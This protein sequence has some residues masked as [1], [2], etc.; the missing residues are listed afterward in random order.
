MDRDPD[1][2][3]RFGW[4]VEDAA[5]W[6]CEAAIERFREAWRIGETA[7]FAVRESVDGPML[8]TV[9]ARHEDDRRVELSWM[10]V[11]AH[12][13]RGIA[14]RA[15]CVLRDW[16]FTTGVD[17]VWASVEHDN[18]PSLRVARSLEMTEHH[19]DADWVHLVVRQSS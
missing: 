4:A 3:R 13:G 9:E 11:P 18:P 6:R 19:R 15:A 16:C 1:V 5:L 7:A 12:R 8:G 14:S 10:T 17:A 2:A